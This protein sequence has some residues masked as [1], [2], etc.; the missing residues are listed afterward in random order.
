MMEFWKV[1]DCEM[2]RASYML[3]VALFIQDNNDSEAAAWREK[4]ERVRREIQGE[5][6]FAEA[7]GEGIYDLIVESWVR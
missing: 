1:A 4:A 7:H 6:Y 5:K 2:A 3:S